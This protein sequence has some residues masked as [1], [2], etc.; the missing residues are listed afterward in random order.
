MPAYKYRLSQISSNPILL[1]FCVCVC[2]VVCFTLERQYSTCSHLQWNPK[3]HIHT[4]HSTRNA[5]TSLCKNNYHAL[6][7]HWNIYEKSRWKWAQL[8]TRGPRK[9][10]DERMSVTCQKA[11]RCRR[12][13]RDAC[14]IH[15]YT[16]TV[17][18][19]IVVVSSGLPTTTSEH[20]HT[21]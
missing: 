4:S 3:W 14:H 18:R 13:R 20:T 10:D 15:I 7:D 8:Y 11:R 9:W 21:H 5:L 1:A 19:R 16:H 6:I 17:C 2:V 12:R